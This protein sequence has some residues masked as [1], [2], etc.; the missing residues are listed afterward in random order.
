NTLLRTA[1]IITVVSTNDH[2]TIRSKDK[3]MAEDTSTLDPTYCQYTIAR[4]VDN[5]TQTSATAFMSCSYYYDLTASTPHL[6]PSTLQTS[7]CKVQACATLFSQFVQYTGDC[8]ILNDDTG[9]QVN[10]STLAGVCS[11]TP[12]TTLSSSSSSPSSNPSGTSTPNTTAAASASKSSSST[13]TIAIAVSVLVLVV[14]FAIYARKRKRRQTKQDDYGTTNLTH[15][16]S[17]LETSWFA[18]NDASEASSMQAQLAH[19]DMFR[20]PA[21]DVKM[22]KPLAE[23]AYGQVW[24]G[25]YNHQVVAVKKLLPNKCSADELLKFIAEIVL[26]SKIDC[27]YVVQFCGAAWTRP[28]DILMVTEYMENGDLRH[29]LEKKTLSWHLKLQ[30]AKNIAEA[31]VYLHCM[32]PRV[33]HRDL[34]SRNVLLDG[35]FRAKLTDFGISREMDDTTMT[36]GIGTYRWMAPEVLQDGHY[37]EA[38]D[39]FSFGV[40]LAELDTEIL[41]YSDLRNERGNPITDTAIMA[42][43]LAGELIPSF[44]PSCPEWYVQIATECLALDPAKRPAATMLAFQLKRCLIREFSQSTPG[45]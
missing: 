12:T 21:A 8:T 39:I 18:L 2:F 5:L 30:C 32:E 45:H 9:A 10:I 24:L 15:G 7:A 40:I 26:L 19:L 13:T 42:K 25:E 4:A 23:G 3:E 38:A 17:S 37:T 28:T 20:I 34:K 43:V 36:A 33:I 1:R 41:P 35:E 6:K 31:L 27:P 29:V 16:P 14:A 44:T 11:S 22:K